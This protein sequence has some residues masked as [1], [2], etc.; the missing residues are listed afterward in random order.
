MRHF[1]LRKGR[2]ATGIQLRVWKYKIRP[3]LTQERL[4]RAANPPVNAVATRLGGSR[5]GVPEAGKRCGPVDGASSDGTRNRLRTAVILARLALHPSV[6]VLGRRAQS[7]VRH[8]LGCSGVF[9]PSSTK[10]RRSRSGVP[11]ENNW[12]RYSPGLGND[13]REKWNTPSATMR[14][15]GNS[16]CVSAPAIGSC[17]SSTSTSRSLSGVFP[18]PSVR[19]TKTARF[20]LKHGNTRASIAEKQ[21]RS[22]HLPVAGSRQTASQ[23]T[24]ASGKGAHGTLELSGSMKSQDNGN[25]TQRQGS[26]HRDARMPCPPKLQIRV[27][28]GRRCPLTSRPRLVN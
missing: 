20:G 27:L 15:P 23:I 1:E 18:R 21:P 19:E 2:R 4:P 10:M 6:G 11:P 25:A 13:T 14:G 3:H 22:V 17:S 12:K 26:L 28:C 16:T 5:K 24:I 7:Q 8:L 9:R